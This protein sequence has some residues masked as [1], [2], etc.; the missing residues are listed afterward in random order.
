MEINFISCIK[1]VER[2]V[3][4]AMLLMLFFSESHAQDGFYKTYGHIT[5]GSEGRNVA[6]AQDGGYFLTYYIYYGGAWTACLAKLN[7]AGKK[8]WEIFFENGAA[9]MPLHIIPQENNGCL[10]SL[11]IQKPGG[12]WST[13]I[14]SINAEGNTLW[15]ASLDMRAAAAT[16]GMAQGNDGSIYVCGS[17][18]ITAPSTYGTAIAKF[19]DAGNLQ[20]R[21]HYFD[22]AGHTVL[23]M[24][25]TK[26]NKLAV[27]GYAPFNTLP[28]TNMFVFLCNAEGDFLMRK[29]FSTYYDDEP[30]SICGDN[31]GNIYVTGYSYFLQS[32]W[33]I[34]FLKLN[35]KLEVLQSKY[36]DGGTAQ[37]EQARYIIC[38]DD[39][40]VAFFGDEGGFNERNPFMM[41]LDESGNVQ[42]A[43][44]YPVS[45]LFTNY[46]YS[47]A[48]CSDGG[49]LMTGDARPASL[50]RIAPLIKTKPDG[51]MGCFTNPYSI[52]ARNEALSEIDTA[53]AVA[54]ITDAADTTAIASPL[55]APA[56][57]EAA[58]CEALLPCGNFSVNA[59]T[60]CP[61]VCYTFSDHSVNADSWQWTFAEGNPG[62]SAEKFPPQVCYLPGSYKVTLQLTNAN[63][64]VSYT[65][66]VNA[67]PDCP[68]SIPNVFTPN[69]DL[70]NES[71]YAK[72]IDESF[73]LK[74]F[75]RWG[76]EIYSS[77][78][79][80]KWW[81]GKSKTG[82][83]VPQGVYYYIITLQNSNK[84]F[85]GMVELLR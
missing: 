57:F 34:M 85:K 83:R 35:S 73:S 82:S 84:K 74:I 7:C 79:P 78:F 75:N 69:G 25:V 46:I 64:T 68:V 29:I 21:R 14:I 1:L 38:T 76:N 9:T 50:F 41:K 53:L 62:F 39:K 22:N 33:D 47:G 80:G 44:S 36:Y 77:D 61:S 17:V 37:G 48:Q 70:F 12:L 51:N 45:P 19:S 59:V 65:Q 32:Q 13:A 24:T 4:A 20:W 43:K 2:K 42:W 6:Q 16:G 18:L 72:G 52:S 81:D 40:G 63:G 60:Q 23:G 66:Y 10:L 31:A 54:V 27:F 30:R 55:N 8:V 11:S 49:Y 58:F 26:E 3:I 15:T 5:E 28:F 56:T 71:F 67:V